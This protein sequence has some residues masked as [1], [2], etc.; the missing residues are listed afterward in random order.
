MMLALQQA[1]QAYAID[2]VPV[3]AVIVK[4]DKII[5]SGY[6]QRETLQMPTAHAEIIAIN[7]AAQQLNSWRLHGCT[8]YVTMEPCSMCAGALVLGRLDKVVFAVYDPKGGACGSVFDIVNEKKLN[9][10]I[11]VVGGILE[12]ESRTLIQSFFKEKRQRKK[13]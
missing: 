4:D 5:S 10:S 11:E 7:Q 12:N 13:K 9:H 2:E 3:G 8:M 6:N 1:K